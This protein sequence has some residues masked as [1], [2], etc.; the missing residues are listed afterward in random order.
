M[1][2]EKACLVVGR[3]KLEF[4]EYGLKIPVFSDVFIVKDVAVHHVSGSN[5]L[6]GKIN[7]DG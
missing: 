2:K 3:Q 6:I 4:L 7:V 1:R 5:N